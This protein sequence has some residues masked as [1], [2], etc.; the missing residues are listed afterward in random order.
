MAATAGGRCRR[1]EED[2]ELAGIDLAADE[3]LV[4]VNA[5]GDEERIDA[6]ALCRGE[7]GAHRIADGENARAFD[8]GATQ[9]AGALKAR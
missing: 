9:L 2:R 5:R 3:H 6:H 8:L 4:A 7:I 1:R